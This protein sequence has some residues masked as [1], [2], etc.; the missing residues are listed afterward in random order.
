MGDWIKDAVNDIKAGKSE[1]EI[2][3][4]YNLGNDPK[5]LRA[6]QGYNYLRN[7]ESEEAALT[8]YPELKTRIEGPMPTFPSIYPKYN[9]G[10]DQQIKSGQSTNQPQKQPAKE[11]LNALDSQ[12]ANLKAMSKGE[13]VKAS[14][15]ISMF[16]K[17]EARAKELEKMDQ[18]AAVNDMFEKNFAKSNM[19]KVLEGVNEKKAEEE[20]NTEAI[21]Q[22]ISAAKYETD[23]T[24]RFFHQVLN[25]ILTTAQKNTGNMASTLI[26]GIG[27]VVSGVT[28][29]RG[30]ETL[31]DEKA[32]NVKDWFMRNQSSVVAKKKGKA[33]LTEP[34][35]QSGSLFN[36]EGFNGHAVVPR[37]METLT[38]MYYLLTGAQAAGGG[39]AGLLASSYLLTYEDGRQE[40]LKAG[41]NNE[42]AEAYAGINSSIQSALELISPN[43]IVFGKIKSKISGEILKKITKEMTKKE[44]IQEA[45]KLWGKEVVGENIQE[46]TQTAAEKGLKWLYNTGVV[47]G[48]IQGFEGVE[49]T[50]NEIL[51]TIILT[52]LATGAIS[53]PGIYSETKPSKMKVGAYMTAADDIPAFQ[54]LL[55]RKVQDGSIA[56][57]DAGKIFGDVE[58]FAKRYE[59][60]KSAGFSDD[61]AGRMAW[62]D[63]GKEKLAEVPKQVQDNPTL[64]AAITQTVQAQQAELENDA[65]DAVMG[66]PQAGEIV[67][68]DIVA[69]MMTQI[70]D[71]GT[72]MTEKRALEIAADDYQMTEVDLEALYD[73]NKEFRAIADQYKETISPTK[74]KEGETKAPVD[75][76]IKNRIKASTP[77]GLRMPAIMS[78]NKIVDGMHRLAQQY[79][80]GQEVARVFKA[81][82]NA[83]KEADEAIKNFKNSFSNWK[84]GQDEGNIAITDKTEGNGEIQ[85]QEEGQVL[86]TPTATE[87]EQDQ[88]LR[89]TTSVGPVL[90][91]NPARQEFRQKEGRYKVTYDDA[92]NRVIKARNGRPI[93]PETPKGRQALARHARN[94]NYDFGDKAGDKIDEAPEFGGNE[95]QINDWMAENSNNPSE[96]AL[97]YRNAPPKENALSEKE[98]AI[99]NYG[100]HITADSYNM[101]GD[102]NNMDKGKRLRYVRKDGISADVLAKSIS[103]DTGLDIGPEDIINFIDDYPGGVA[104]ALK[105][106]EGQAQTSARQKFEKITGI[107]LTPEVVDIAVQQYLGEAKVSELES[108]L[109]DQFDSLTDDQIE[110]AIIDTIQEGE[111]SSVFDPEDMEAFYDNYT[112]SQENDQAETADE[113]DQSEPEI[114]EDPEIDESFDESESPEEDLPEV[115]GEVGKQDEVGKKLSEFKRGDL[116]R[117]IYP[118]R[119]GVYKI[120]ST[121]GPVWKLDLLDENGKRVTSYDFNALNN[122]GFVL[123]NQK[124]PS[125]NDKKHFEWFRMI[126]ELKDKLSVP[127]HMVQAGQDVVLVTFYSDD[128]VKT[129]INNKVVAPPKK[130]FSM[131]TYE[132]PIPGKFNANLIFTSATWKN[133]AALINKYYKFVLVENSM[134]KEELAT[135]KELVRLAFYPD[136]NKKDISIV[137]DGRNLEEIEDELDEIIDQQEDIE[138]PGQLDIEKQIKQAQREYDGAVARLKE[139]SDKLAKEQAKQSDIFGTGQQQG[140][141]AQTGEE[142]KSILDPLKKEVKERK[143]AFDKLKN[144]QQVGEDRQNPSIFDGDIITFKASTGKT[145]VGKTVEIPNLGLDTAIT[146]QDGLGNTSMVWAV[147]ELATGMILGEGVS[148]QEA[149]DAATNGIKGK[150][151]QIRS[152]LVAWRNDTI[153]NPARV[154]PSPKLDKLISDNQPT[155]PRYTPEE[156][157][158]ILKVAEGYRS[159]GEEN[160]AESFERMANFKKLPADS[161]L[162]DGKINI[163]AVEK[164]LQSKIDGTYK[165]SV[166]YYDLPEVNK[167]S[168]EALT[169]RKLT[170][171]KNDYEKT[172]EGIKKSGDIFSNEM[173]VAA[174]KDYEA[175]VEKINQ[176]MADRA[177]AEAPVSLPQIEKK[178]E[179]NTDRAK[180]EANDAIKNF[181]ESFKKWKEGGQNLGF[182]PEEDAKRQAQMIADGIIAVKSLMKVGI[183][184]FVDMVDAI[185]DFAKEFGEGAKDFFEAF[186]KAYVS[187]Y[188]ED[189]T[190]LM[191]DPKDVKATTMKEVDTPISDPA[192][193]F[194]LSV[195]EAINNGE[196]LDIRS[197]RSLAERHNYN[198]S[199]TDLQEMVEFALVDMARFIAEKPWTADQKLAAITDLYNKQP[200]LNMRD[201]DRVKLQQYSTPLPI[202]FIAGQWLNL[203]GYQSVLEPSAGNGM[204]VH[205]IRKDALYVNEIDQVRNANL[206]KQGYASVTSYD[207]INPFPMSGYGG[208]LM[209][210][211]FGKSK[212]QNFDGFDLEGLEEVMTAH[213]LNA[214]APSGRAAIIIGGHMKYN[215][216]GIISGSEWRFFNYLYNKYNVSDVINIDGD[217][218]SKQG[219]KFPI[220]MILID[221]AKSTPSGEAPLKR[222]SSTYVVKSFKE[223]HNRINTLH[224]N[225]TTMEPDTTGSTGVR[226]IQPTK[227]ISS[228]IGGPAAGQ[229][230]EADQTGNKGG[231]RPR[232]STG[233][234]SRDNGS[235]QPVIGDLFGGNTSVSPISETTEDVSTGSQRKA[236]DPAATKRDTGII[237]GYVAPTVV[238]PTVNELLESEK[239]NYVPKSQAPNLG[240]KIPSS[241]YQEMMNVLDRIAE[242]Y[243]DIDTFVQNE[244]QYPTRQDLYNALRAEQIDA[245]ALAISNIKKGQAAIIGDMT[246]IGKGRVAASII[247]YGVIQGKKPWFITIQPNLFSD[248][249]RDL[250]GI[251]SN[252]L[253]PLPMHSEESAN[254]QEDD[255]ENPEELRTVFPRMKS[256]NPDIQ[257]MIKSGK[258]DE[259]YDFAMTTYSQFTEKDGAQRRAFLQNTAEG[260]II[261][262]DEA[263]TASGTSSI[264]EFFQNVSQSTDGVVFLS[265]TYAKRPDNMPLYAAKTVLSEAQLTP[266]QMTEAFKKGGVALQEIV[267]S[268]LVNEGQLVRREHQYDAD[269]ISYKVLTQYSKRDRERADKIVD[270]IQEIIRF[271]KI[272]VGQAKQAIKEGLNTINLLE[273]R[274]GTDKMGIKNTPFASKVFNLTSQLLLCLKAES[275]AEEAI[276]SLKN[277]EKPVITLSNTMESMLDEFNVDEA[278]D[279]PD[280]SIVMKKGLDGVMKLSKKDGRKKTSEPI[281]LTPDDLT[282]E[283]RSE[284]YRILSKIRS[285][286]TGLSISPL[287]ILLDKITAAGYSVSEL[288]GRSTRVDFK[289]DGSAFVRSY[290]KRK[291][292]AEVKKFQSGTLD[293]VII[294]ASASTGLSLHADRNALDQRVRRELLMQMNLDPNTE[295]QIRGRVDR[296]NQVHRGKYTYIISDIPAETRL[297]MMF[298]RKMRSLDANTS[299]KQNMKTSEINTVDFINKYGDQIVA[300]YLLEH[301]DINEMLNDPLKIEDMS[302]EEK[303]TLSEDA[304]NNKYGDV[305]MKVTG[306]VAALS[307]ANQER[308]YNDISERYNALIEQKISNNENDLEVN[309]LDLQ[310]ET[311]K[312]KEIIDGTG[313]ASLF[314]SPVVL[315][316]V[317]ARILSKPFTIAELNER[318]SE[319]E[320]Q[321]ADD[322]R[323]RAIEYYDNKLNDDIKK[324]TEREIERLDDVIEDI[325]ERE[326][327]APQDIIDGMIKD[328]R[329]RSSFSLK[330]KTD[331]LSARYG[332]KKSDAES[333]FRRFKPGMKVMMPLNIGSLIASPAVFLGYKINEKASNPFAPSAIRMLFAVNDERR[334]VTVVGSDKGMLDSVYNAM[335][336]GY[337]ILRAPIEDFWKVN[338]AATEKRFIMTGNLLKA[339]GEVSGGRLVQYTTSSGDVKK[340]YLMNKEF[341]PAKFSTKVNVASPTVYEMAIRSNEYSPL[342]LYAGEENIEAEVWANKYRGEAY[343]NVPKSTKVGGKYFKNDELLALVYDGNFNQRGKWMRGTLPIENFQ[344]LLTLLGNAFGLKAIK[345]ADRSNAFD[346]IDSG[347]PKSGGKSVTYNDLKDTKSALNKI[348]QFFKGD[349]QITRAIEF[350]KPILAANPNIKLVQAQ[351]GQFADGADGKFL[352]AGEV[353]L[354]FDNMASDEQIYRTYL[355][356]MIHAATV[357]EMDNNPAFREE[358]QSILGEVREALGLPADMSLI[359][360]TGRQMAQMGAYGAVNE[361][362]MLA[363]IFTDRQFYDYLKK[364]PYKGDVSMI[365][366]I[367]MRIIQFFRKTYRN[368]AKAKDSIQ[369][370]NLANVIM[371]LTEATIQPKPMPLSQRL[372]V[373]NSFKPKYPADI[374][375]DFIRRKDL[376]GA[377][378][379]K[380]RDALKIKLGITEAEA[381]ALIVSAVNEQIETDP[382][383]IVENTVG[384]LEQGERGRGLI[385]RTAPVMNTAIRNRL[386]DD[387]VKYFQVSNKQTQDEADVYLS[388]F[389]ATAIYDW[390]TD[391]ATEKQLNALPGRVKVFI[392]AGAIKAMGQEAQKLQM[393]MD[394][395]GA[396]EYAKK[397]ERLYGVIAPLGTEWGQ[398]V[399]AFRV[400]AG[401]APSLMKGHAENMIAEIERKLGKKLSDTDKQAIRDLV[402]EIEKLPEGL[403]RSKK[404]KELG[405]MIAIMTNQTIP[406]FDI[407]QGIWYA[408][409]LSGIGTQ[410]KNMFANLFNSIMEFA[411]LGLRE[412]IKTR[413][414]SIL[415]FMFGAWWDGLGKGISEAGNIMTT[416]LTRDVV[417]KFGQSPMLEWFTWKSYLGGKF[418]RK[419]AFFGKILDFP[420]FIGVSPKALRYVGRALAAADAMLYYANAEMASGAFA[421]EHA[422]IQK[423]ADP[424]IKVR[425]TAK[426]MMGNVKGKIDVFEKQAEKEGFAPG[427]REFRIRT[428]ELMVSSRDPKMAEVGDKY[429]AKVTF[430]YEPDGLLAPW[431]RSLSQFSNSHR[432]VKFFMPFMR[433]VTNLMENYLNYTPVG[434]IKAVKGNGKVDSK[435]F[436]KLTQD[437]RA[438]LYVKFGMGSTM[439]MAMFLLG[440]FDD[441]DDGFIEV[442]G[443]GTGDY[444]KNYELM[445][446]GWREYSIRIGGTNYSYKDTPLFA[447]LAGIG[448]AA[449]HYKFGNG[450]PN[451]ATVIEKFHVA[452][453]GMISAMFDQ[454]WM[455]GLDEL[456]TATKGVDKY[457]R[458]QNFGGKMADAAINIG[459]GMAMTNFTTQLIRVIREAL[460]EPIK[461]ASGVEKIYR[462]IPYLND[463]MN[464]IIDVWGQEVVPEQTLSW[465]PFRAEFEL[466]IDPLNEF[467]AKKKIFVGMPERRDVIDY[468]TGTA[469]PMDDQQYYDFVKKSGQLSKE[470][471][472]ELFN[473]GAL[474][475][476]SVI[477]IKRAVD[478][479]RRRAREDAYYDL[480]NK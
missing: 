152:K 321:N 167:I 16:N 75:P 160:L 232:T 361:Y 12:M 418:G 1:Q 80:N 179:T 170:K 178:S 407:M 48:P 470:Y 431:Y 24:Y 225:S 433:I 123:H 39:S 29:E 101:F 11:E 409:I 317:N 323:E 8:A 444:Q 271:Q 339:I 51:E 343:I 312:Q 27:D 108:D 59:Q 30:L 436:R 92:G 310:A 298:K 161:V 109:E 441:D 452:A 97:I 249:W 140:L 256:S 416:G 130:G 174:T 44:V 420:A 423:A 424:N 5:I 134:G 135:A 369:D 358:M 173:I 446:A 115:T 468:T 32:A 347:G 20:K 449:D 342:E 36:D 406:F 166:S 259:K 53:T 384:P 260:N 334:S 211:P 165:E 454:S 439:A 331:K 421:W 261:I 445:K 391:P 46:L 105:K 206:T 362:E 220:R 243:G 351:P 100:I 469:V 367:I 412:L 190:G 110:D 335:S 350:L 253:V 66:I 144:Q 266:E 112:K 41:L 199:D 352:G 283:G 164:M 461:R 328:A 69:K 276:A 333:I 395:D 396:Q 15:D 62:A 114:E 348:E 448:I 273:N 187:A 455:S 240:T 326:K 324:I 300:E 177:K 172:V 47:E 244:L 23:P 435:Y 376:E 26:R 307:I 377:D 360:F 125:A 95:D 191:D 430:N 198:A 255:P 381:D 464:P 403:P 6:V 85:R 155:E 246:G 419:G 270:L 9:Q 239:V 438:E 238:K 118:N 443:N 184:K 3:K 327:S 365:E 218:Y 401:I 117:S 453:M 450:D 55:S 236:G 221:G 64:H 175:K 231:R 210:P 138:E 98:V 91:S 200:S 208:V 188:L 248:M 432:S 224:E 281:Q 106:T 292:N 480:F 133:L 463:N 122:D 322:L 127:E 410:A 83:K 372:G 52:T 308:F 45:V 387:T 456:V 390:L 157:A 411:N 476:M 116:V 168:N 373:M 43:N 234:P 237:S 183:Y 375:R 141:F 296:T 284:Y 131:A 139:A 477:D 193:E 413:D 320:G 263:H 93:D 404:L 380:V 457:G 379:T 398:S 370:R 268:Q 257:R 136:A 21:N 72:A 251:G 272:H 442:T 354:N 241:M 393:A 227:I 304:K 386:E 57:E 378:M 472:G 89:G 31:A 277:N 209:N 388:Q 355:H 473:A 353:V 214:M 181:K 282:P 336:S 121:S 392:Y 77:E 99:A 474:N 176:Q 458:T 291:K 124:L 279:S 465:K 247:R 363:E 128:P 154:N 340:G 113:Q 63:R 288:T 18:L 201:S 315:E 192:A 254:V 74:P 405:E 294:N 217:L 447:M 78:G 295:V 61:Q 479:E 462:D 371:S 250:K 219:T 22:A 426:D 338:Q 289:D 13:D 147:Y 346:K 202:S 223:L 196:K 264:G 287:D 171:A 119:D 478:I 385:T 205:N 399:Q 96:L 275:V 104:S 207:A 102:P 163:D 17:T 159:L 422:M 40:G 440:A 65:K 297:L 37:T 357:N 182:S 344:K 337:S 103:D 374:V 319:F 382:A 42:Q 301:E 90:D 402:D 290:P 258:I 229:V 28:G 313:G 252:N 285:T 366:R 49:V 389:P 25:P 408:H 86:D 274:K 242:E 293:C 169:K 245:V 38:T 397:G 400:F 226:D 414:L 137:S 34:V 451:D 81:L 142:N 189:T 33:F 19:G 467:L 180:K 212:V 329:E 79:I 126:V 132:K 305:A 459:R 269:Q 203:K 325:K 153:K 215:D 82:P 94:Y 311:I 186:K 235:K 383:V 67:R 356:E 71:K 194:I 278:L 185:G 359:G 303:A 345:E 204:L 341:N 434:L 195:K 145:Y 265:A 466:D 475:N 394:F 427:T 228:G 197:L 7:T 213:A 471:I 262:L 429:G 76:E 222:E 4:K 14:G 368:I 216:E 230:S 146:N 150:E 330:D 149:I 316:Q 111:K 68:G 73:G 280:F 425:A 50:K 364:T 10:Q 302:D 88:N 162:I 129:A 306:Q 417:A 84:Q 428:N 158:R 415:P 156:Q 148:E 267:S 107:P 286:S 349:P 2:L 233:R 318:K 332:V 299:A 151:V 58:S 120:V 35:Q 143:E 460:D 60:N 56:E 70:G 314:G 309:V 87:Q 54:E 437:E